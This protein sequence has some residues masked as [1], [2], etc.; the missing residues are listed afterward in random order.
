VTLWPE[1]FL[2]IIALATL[3]TAIMQVGVLLTAGRMLR[4][5]QQLIDRVD[6][7]LAPT[8][9]HVNVI[10]RDVSRAV[11]LATTQ[12]QRVD[13]LI[14]DLTQRV[15]DLG[16]SVQ[17]TLAMPA[18]EGK[19]ILNALKVA[20]DVLREARRRPGRRRVEDDDALFI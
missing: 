18:R 8:F 17:K 11:A 5:V 19:A 1:I 3:A 15:E 2:G 12:V 13:Q 10:S 4:H 14:S 16:T 9:G 7:E 6:K 20:L